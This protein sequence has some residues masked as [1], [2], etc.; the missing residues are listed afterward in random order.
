MPVIMQTGEA[1]YTYV[2]RRAEEYG[3]VLIDKVAVD[4]ELAPAVRQALGL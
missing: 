3:I 4:I 2:R 1:K